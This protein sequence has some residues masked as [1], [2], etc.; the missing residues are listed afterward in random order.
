MV[1]PVPGRDGLGKLKVI[2][3][4]SHVAEPGDLWLERMEPAFKDRAPKVVREADADRFY[5]DGLRP[6]RV[7]AVATSGI[8]MTEAARLRFEDG[9]RGGW[10]PDARIKDM[11]IDGVQ[12]DVL[13][14]SIGLKLY[15]LEDTSFQLACMKA[16]NDWLADFCAADPSRFK[17]IGLL[18]TDAETAASELQRVADLGLSGGMIAI[19]P[20]EDRHYS[21]ETYDPLWKAAEALG[22][23]L[24]LHINTALGKGVSVG[25]WAAD[26][27]TIPVWIERS[28]TIM[29]CSGVF[30]R[31]PGL[32]VVSAENDIG[33]AGLF[34]Q[35]MDHGMERHGASRGF[36]LKAK[37]SEYFHR[38]VFCTFMD[39][40][41]GLRIWD[42]IG[43]DNILWSNDYPHAD[44]IWPNSQEINQRQFKGIPDRVKEKALAGNARNLYGFP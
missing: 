24:S 37:P 21:A 26:Y 27:V 28:L 12:G 16:Y 2:S 9:R 29:I 23:P 44:S 36:K 18:P 1:E 32:R 11:A 41:A 15:K 4:D 3:A 20:G 7:G 42:I 5:C 25:N 38:N 34:L 30:E 6:T 10:D 43:E 19:Y 35:R 31:F 22:M 17:G 33:W 39:D 13:Y 8:S 14:A 40:E